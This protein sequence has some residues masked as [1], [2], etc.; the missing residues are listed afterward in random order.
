MQLLFSSFFIFYFAL[1]ITIEFMGPMDELASAQQLCCFLS[2][3]LYNYFVQLFSLSGAR[4]PKTGRYF[5]HLLG[6]LSGLEF[7]S[8]IHTRRSIPTHRVHLVYNNQRMNG[9]YQVWF[10][11]LTVSCSPRSRPQKRILVIT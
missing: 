5:A 2:Y 6:D 7:S 10:G 3:Q 9:W 4:V 8:L 11:A 1:L